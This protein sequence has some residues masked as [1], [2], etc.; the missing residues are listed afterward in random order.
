MRGREIEGYLSSE[1]FNSALTE[2]SFGG[3]IS[4]RLSRGFGEGTFLERMHVVLNAARLR[5]V[6]MIYVSV[7][8]FCLLSYVVL[9][10]L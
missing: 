1:E 5:N 10:F 6:A 4:P 9:S 7:L 2:Q 8:C 3:F